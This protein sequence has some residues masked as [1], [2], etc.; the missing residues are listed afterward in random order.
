MIQIEDKASIATM[1]ESNCRILSKPLLFQGNLL[2]IYIYTVMDI[3]WVLPYDYD[4]P[5]Q[6]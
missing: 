6:L 2:C 3:W 5:S 4:I 1:L